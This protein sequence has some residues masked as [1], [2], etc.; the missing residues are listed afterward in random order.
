M[1]YIAIN[2]PAEP[3]PCNNNN[4]FICTPRHGGSAE[5]ALP[6]AVLNQSERKRRGTA[7]NPLSVHS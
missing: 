5:P 6:M 4:L 7:Y 3:Q 1:D 2:I